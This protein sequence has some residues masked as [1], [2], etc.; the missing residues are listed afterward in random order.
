MNTIASFLVN[1]TK[2]YPGLY[3]SRKDQF[4]FDFVTTFDMRITRPNVEPVMDT[5]GIHAIEHLGATFLRNDKIWST[6]I[7]YFGPMGCRTGFYLVMVGD[8]YPLDIYKLVGNMV[9]YILAYEGKLPGESEVE[10]GNYHDLDLNLAKKY[11][12]KYKKEVLDV[13]TKERYIYPEM[14]TT[15]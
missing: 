3:I 6:K 5:G 9:E 2:L 10:C 15:K 8:L 13:F 7:I 4:G 14:E 11:M 12:E 1:H